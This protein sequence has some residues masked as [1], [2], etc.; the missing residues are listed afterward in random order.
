MTS[1]ELPLIQLSAY[2]DIAGIADSVERYAGQT[3]ADRITSK[4]LGGIDLLASTRYLGP[5]HQDPILARSGYRKL[6]VGKYV[7]VYRVYEGRATVLR[8]FHGPSNY[9]SKVDG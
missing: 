4:T 6:V 8:I 9:V 1:H 5:L 7:V 3:A 2:E